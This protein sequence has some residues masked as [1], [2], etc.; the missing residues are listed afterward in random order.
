[1]EA[2]SAPVAPATAP[3]PRVRGDASLPWIFAGSAFLLH[4]LFLTRYGIFRDELYYLACAD[5]MAWGYVDHPP[6]SIAVLWL[7]RAVLG[8]ALWAIRLP[9]SLALAAVVGL[10]GWLAREVGG[11]KGAQALAMLAALVAPDYL[12]VGHFFSMNAFDVLLWTAVFCVLSRLLRAPRPALWFWF[13]ALLGLGL[14]NK[15]S[16]LWLIAGVGVGLLATPPR[17]LFLTPGPWLAA[18][19]TALL[20]APHI[21]WQVANGWPTLEFIHNATTQKMAPLSPI[22]FILSQ[23]L[24]MNPIAAPI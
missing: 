12:A 5:H 16:M 11:G 10:T 17:R 20:Y 14:L 9:P 19:V 22:Q 2:S 21:A 1:V 7:T 3:A 15:L 8:D 4:L 23:L 6:L 13:G 18:A 24:L